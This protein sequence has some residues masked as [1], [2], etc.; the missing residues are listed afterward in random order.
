MEEAAVEVG[1]DVYEVHCCLLETETLDVGF[2]SAV[3]A[4]GTLER[5]SAVLAERSFFVLI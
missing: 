2:L 5:R 4:V 3:R 1:E